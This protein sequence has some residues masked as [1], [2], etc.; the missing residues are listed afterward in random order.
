MARCGVVP[1]RWT[2]RYTLVSFDT[3]DFVHPKLKKLP[4]DPNGT[5]PLQWLCFRDSPAHV[6]AI[7]GT[8]YRSVNRNK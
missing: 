2:Q 4:L 1:A 8:E 3:N 6:A 5:E 7:H